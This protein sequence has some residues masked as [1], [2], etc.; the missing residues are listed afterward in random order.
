MIAAS[1]FSRRTG[2]AAPLLLVGLGI[3]ASYLPSTPAIH[4]EPELILAGVLP[5]LLYS[6][7]VNLPVIDVRRNLALIVWLSGGDGGRLGAGDRR[8]GPLGVPEHLVRA[9]HRPRRGGQPDRRGRRDGDRATG[10]AAAAAD[11]RARG[12]EP[13]QR[14]LGPRRPAHRGRRDRR[15]RRVLARRTRSWTSPGRWPAPRSSARSSAVLTALL[16]QRLDD[17]VLNTTIS[18]AV[19]FLAYFPAEEVRRLRRAR[20]RRR[21]PASPVRSAAGASA[22]GTGRPRRRPGRRSASSSRAG[23]SSRWA[24]SCRSSSTP[25]AARPRSGRSPGWCCSW[26]RCWW[27]CGSLGLAGPA[28]ADPARPRPA[29]ATQKR[30]QL[31]PVRGAAGRDDAGRASARRTGWPGPGSGWPGARPTSSSR[32]ASRSPLAAALVVAWAGMRGVVTVAAAQTIPAGTPHRAT[33][34]LAAFLVALI[35][36]VLFGLTLPTVIATDAVPFREPG[37]R[38]RLGPG[39]PATGRRVGRRHPRPAGGADRRRRTGRPGA[40]RAR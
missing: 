23:S 30:A 39:P 20:R 17:P 26:S 22:P 2:V 7:A 3:A 15:D 28:I 13:G 10:R 35:T 37:G 14:R 19:P 34:V 8:G 40:G 16:R 27:R 12:R 29:A 33:V 18:F 36:L 11:G 24:T 1:V 4:V 9:R 25:P 6:S 5:P 21:R 31:G 32:S 38:A